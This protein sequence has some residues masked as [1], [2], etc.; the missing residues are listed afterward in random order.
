MSFKSSD[1]DDAAA[2]NTEHMDVVDS[3]G[4]PVDPPRHKRNWE[5]ASR[6]DF[7]AALKEKDDALKEKDNALK[8]K[9]NALKEKDNA[10]K[11]KDNALKEKDNALKEKDNEVKQCKR[12]EVAKSLLAA[13]K[14]THIKKLKCRGTGSSNLNPKNHKDAKIIVKDFELLASRKLIAKI[15]E[16][17]AESRQD[18]SLE[19]LGSGL[20]LHFLPSEKP[21]SQTYSSEADVVKKVN[22]VL[23]DA[24]KICNAMIN[25]DTSVEECAELIVRNE[26]SLF[27]NRCDHVVV[28]DSK[29]NT[30]IF[31]V[32]TKKHFGKNFHQEDSN[33]TCGQSYD[34]LKAM[35]TQGHPFPLGAIT[36]F[37]ETY[38][39]SL[40]PD[41][42]WDALPTLKDLGDIAER[43]PESKVPAN[44]TPSP[45]KMESPSHTRPRRVQ[46]SSG[47]FVK[48]KSRCIVRSQKY[49]EPKNLVS[50][51]VIILLR[52]A[53][54]F[55]V[56]KPLPKL[57]T[58][59]R[60]DIHCIQ[61][62]EKS[63]QW[64]TLCTTYQGPFTKSEHLH[65]KTLHLIRCIGNGSTSKAYY[66]MTQD[67][68]DCVVKMYVQSHDDDGNMKSA[69]KF[70]TDS[71][72][73][74]EKEKEN[75]SK[76]Y[77]D[78][79]CVEIQ[80]LNGYDCIILPFFEPILAEDRS[81]G[82][83]LQSIR[84]R[85]QQFAKHN[86]AFEK[87][88][89]MWRHVG[90]FNNKIYLFDLGDLVICDNQTEAKR[91]VNEHYDALEIK[92][93]VQDP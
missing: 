3:N 30:P 5:E 67:G 45:L 25:M 42:D 69:A 27:S 64:G 28:C 15:D 61:V 81:N 91:C 11:E 76:I 13:I 16:L 39:T 38:M 70:K 55:Y 75:Y 20:M 2:S 31:C 59:Q 29:S 24:V 48:D 8:E 43:L 72:D 12:R 18:P 14:G 71:K 44:R 57:S 60:F 53:K 10:L 46:T 26:M 84:N 56:L 33:Q 41:L 86:L 50:A 21:P 22:L 74:V 49:I 82:A 7:L 85:L 6:E 51:F 34:Q 66:A 88:D 17:K 77:G 87:C 80:Q 83:V 32:E 54:G 63:Y 1:D 23:D 9:D 90:R 47:E 58:Y 36:C 78:E 73:H 4:D 40:S 92:S 65:E 52:A 68:Y 35:Q 89:R 19:I 79:L 37:N 62:T 93:R